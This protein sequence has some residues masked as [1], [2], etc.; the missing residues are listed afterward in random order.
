VTGVTLPPGAK[1][2]LWSFDHDTGRWEIAGPMTVT[3]D[4]FFAETDPGVGVRQP[5]WHGAG[6]GGPGGGPDC[7]DGGRDC[8]RDDDGSEDCETCD[9]DP[10]KEPPDCNFFDPFCEGNN[11]RKEARLLAN[12]V[13]D[14]VEDIGASHLGG[15]LPGCALGI[16]TSAMRAA[17]DCSID[18]AAC[19]DIGI[20]NPI[21]DG[22][23][24]SALGCIPKVGS[25]LSPAWTFKSVI[26]NI[27]A[28]ED[29]AGRQARQAG[30]HGAT[31]GGGAQ[32]AALVARLKGLLN[33]QLEVCE[34]SSN[35]VAAWFGP[36]WAVAQTPQD[37]GVYATFMAAVEAAVQPDGDGGRT[38]TAGE[39]GGLLD[40]PRPAAASLTD[41]DLLI[42]RLNRMAAG[43]FRAGQPDADAFLAAY[44]RLA[45]VI[46][47]REAEG[48]QTLWD[49]L[50]RVATVL[51][52]FAEPVPD[53]GTYGA[54]NPGAPD[55]VLQAVRHATAP[56]PAFPRRAH[57]FV[58]QDLATGFL[59]R[60]RLTDQGRLPPLILAPNRRYA[61][62]YLDPANG[63]RGAALF[64]SAASGRRT[65]IPAAP[66]IERDGMDRDG[67]GLADGAEFIL[68]TEPNLPDT[69]GDGVTDGAEFLAGGEPLGA[70]ALPFGVIGGAD[71]PGQA[72]DLAIEGDLAVVLDGTE[73]LALFDLSDPRS[74]VRI[75]QFPLARPVSIALSGGIA[76]VGQSGGATLL[77]LRNPAAPLVLTNF[78]GT[79]AY[80]V[81]L[82]APYGY[83]S[84]GT[85]VLTVDLVSGVLLPPLGLPALVDEFAVDGDRL[86]VLT[87]QALHIFRR[88][89]SEL[90]EHSRTPVA[91]S[92]AP[93]EVGRKLFAGGG[94]AYVG[95][96]AG[97]T[98]FNVANPAAPVVLATQPATQA[99]I[100]DFAD[101]GSGLLA[102]ITSFSGTG[103][104]AFSLYDVAAGT[105][106]TNFLTSLA[107]PGDP[108]AVVLHRGL[109]YVADDEAGLQV[110]NS[111]PRDT[112][113]VRPAIAFGPPLS[114]VP[115]LE[116]G[117]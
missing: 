8:D 66:L 93:L 75:T 28:V 26:F 78:P 77:D 13:M 108:F 51:A 57:F 107:T 22:A 84:R 47:A 59:Q 115:V 12:S 96:F 62:A 54:W 112:A 103:S 58:L 111:L 50:F 109:A 16:G 105:T 85:T 29:C 17:R 76:L 36:A 7:E 10:P 65:R 69:D 25:I 99:A 71:T 14:L 37:A 94:R 6:P 114:V 42:T 73:G 27:A 30:L 110:I 2:A 55:A 23:I 104:L 82:A 18:I 95:Y 86:H 40:Q 89:G 52:A 56:E 9:D 21:I 92:P 61:V 79:A 70:E 33:R 106:V 45:A 39:L 43:E 48:W 31:V 64:V 4:G 3:A 46:A 49:G 88:I 5:G 35:V 91:G 41:V 80:A 1:T 81:A 113:G 74:P 72:R 98:I 20:S 97:F 32:F 53:A 38:I 24:G 19:G 34:A 44:D 67:D 87:Q 68:G 102:A 116:A 90:A 83:F 63:R 101:N 100:H 117:S 11:C 60:G 15:E